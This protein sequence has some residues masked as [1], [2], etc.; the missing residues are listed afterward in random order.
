[1]TVW[2][3]GAKTQ[4]EVKVGELSDNEKV[5]SATNDQEEDQS[6][7]AGALGMQFA[8][9]TKQLRRE[10]HVAK[11]VQGVVVMRVESG[12]AAEEVGLSRG[13]IVMGIDQQAVRTPQEAVDKLKE[14]A[15]SPKK[16]A[17]LLLNRHGVTQYVG[18]TLGANQG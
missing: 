1:M 2:R 16:S 15:K 10:L 18:L 14:I 12:S 6:A 11:D 17:L 8:P 4:V 7:Q 5:A 9:L 13:D 3:N